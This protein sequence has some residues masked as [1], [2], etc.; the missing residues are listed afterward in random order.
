MIFVGCWKTPRSEFIRSWQPLLYSLP[1]AAV[2]IPCWSCGVAKYLSIL[3]CPST[4][5]SIIKVLYSYPWHSPIVEVIGGSHRPHGSLKWLLVPL[6]FFMC[7]QDRCRMSLIKL[8]GS[9]K[10]RKE[11]IFF[12]QKEFTT[13]SMSERFRGE[14]RKEREVRNTGQ[15]EVAC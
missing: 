10:G 11:L 4:A 3:P 12:Y 7:H 14:R 9:E 5:G 15:L 13:S 6:I 8:R 2:G 1:N